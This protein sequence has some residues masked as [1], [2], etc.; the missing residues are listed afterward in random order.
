MTF[1]QARITDQDD[2]FYLVDVLTAS[3]VQHPL[4]VELRNG[5]KVKIGQFFEDGQASGL[6]PLALAIELTVGHFLFSQSQQIVV[7]FSK[8][9]RVS[10]PITHV[11]S[12]TSASGAPPDFVPN[13]EQG[14]DYYAQVS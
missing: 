9:Y 1:A 14:G 7:S 2:W 6:D 11:W 13:H 4:F 8:L 5:R 10:S 3:Q 12:V